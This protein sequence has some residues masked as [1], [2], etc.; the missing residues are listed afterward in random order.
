MIRSGRKNKALIRNVVFGCLSFALVGGLTALFMSNPFDTK[1]AS[2]AN[3]NPGNIISDYM[4][5]NV[6]TMSLNDIQRFWMSMAIV[7]IRI[8]M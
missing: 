1:A 5:S 7:M 4:M 2:L 6:D 8:Y 3:F